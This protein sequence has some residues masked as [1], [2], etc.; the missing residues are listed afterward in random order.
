MRHLVI[1]VKEPIPGRVKTRLGRGIGMVAAAWW[2]RHQVARLLREVGRD[3]R[4]VTWL[5]V[6]PDVAGLA[7]RVWPA[8]LPRWSQGGGNL[9]DRMGRIFLEMPLGPVV[10]IGADV[11]GVRSCLIAQAFAALRAK[12]AV[13]GPSSDGGYW[14]I[15]LQRASRP[16]PNRLFEGVRWSSEYALADSERSFGTFQ[17]ARI[18]AL[19]DVDTAA[20]LA[21]LSKPAARAMAGVRSAR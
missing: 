16:L 4:W 9:G 11:P 13:M 1:L 8:H 10:I 6:T 15:G 12:D 7:S 21:R 14:L 3:P 20:D 19:D 17:I 18:T 5:A 2:F